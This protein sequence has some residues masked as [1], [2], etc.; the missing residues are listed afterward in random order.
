MEDNIIV[1]VVDFDEELYLKNIQEN[2]FN[3]EYEGGDED[4]NN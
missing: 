2:E 3:E 4:A 1:E